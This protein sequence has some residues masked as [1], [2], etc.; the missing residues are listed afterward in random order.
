MRALW[1]RFQEWFKLFQKRW[2]DWPLVLG[3]VVLFLAVPYWLRRYLD[4]EARAFPVDYLNVLPTSLLYFVYASAVAYTMFRLQFPDLFSDFIRC[5]EKDLLDL[6]EPSV[7]HLDKD[8][9][10]R[11]NAQAW[12]L[13]KT[14][15]TILFCYFFGTLLLEIAVLIIS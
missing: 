9:Y 3:A 6:P 2:N 4:P 8:Y 13:F 14:S 7:Y 10:D 1:R 15:L 12:R 5:L 11:K